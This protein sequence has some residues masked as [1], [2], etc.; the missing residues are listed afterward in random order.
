VQANLPFQRRSLTARR[1]PGATPTPA[2]GSAATQIKIQGSGLTEGQTIGLSSAIGSISVGRRNVWI[3]LPD[4]GELVRLNPITGRRRSFAAAGSPTAIA[5]GSRALWVAETTSRSLAQFNGDSGARVAL[6][7]LAGTPT[8][9]ALDQGDSSAWVADS[10][11]AISHVAL[12]GAVI[13]TPAHSDPAAASIARGEGWLWATNGTDNGL[14]RVSLGP[15]GSST[16]FPAGPR[17]VAVALDQG[18]W[19]A[20]AN[21]HVT[22]FD[23]RPGHL[24]VNADIPVAPEL[25]AIAA[26]DPSPFVW[27]TSK[28]AMALYRVTNTSQPAVTGTIVFGSPPVALAVDTHSVWVATKDGKVTQIRF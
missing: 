1:D 4:R 20:H 17:P 7:T 14:V 21:G 25:D 19:T 13:G 11:G 15:G 26:T 23:P 18:V 2:A 9:I 6:A 3:S 16:A 28:T 12:G 8:A 10:S 24:R 22:R 5:A 27:A